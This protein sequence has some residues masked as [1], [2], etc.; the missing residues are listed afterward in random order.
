MALNKVSD[1][2][3]ADWLSQ[4]HLKNYRN[5]SQ[6]W[7]SSLSDKIVWAIFVPYKNH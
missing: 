4:N 6:W 1:V 7:K 2:F 3:A 5:F